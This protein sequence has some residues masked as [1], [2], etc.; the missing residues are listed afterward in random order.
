MQNFN[1]QE[2]CGRMISKAEEIVAKS[3]RTILGRVA[4]GDNIEDCD[5]LRDVLSA[6]EWF[7]PFIPEVLQEIHSEWINESLDGLYPPVTRKTGERE[8]EI[9]GLCNFISDQTLTQI[10]VHLQIGLSEDKV[11]WLECRL[12]DNSPHGMVRSPS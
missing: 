11:T 12:G 6:L 2:R 10:Y 9:F 4:T 5:D 1:E 7:I 8:V 3:V